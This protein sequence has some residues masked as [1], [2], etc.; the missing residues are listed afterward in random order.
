MI[1]SQKSCNFWAFKYSKYRQPASN[2]NRKLHITPKTPKEIRPPFIQGREDESSMGPT[3]VL[4]QMYLPCMLWR[5]C[6]QPGHSVNQYRINLFD[7]I[8]SGKLHTF[9]VKLPQWR[10]SNTRHGSQ[11][12]RCLAVALGNLQPSLRRYAKP[13][14]PWNVLR[15]NCTKTYKA[16]TRT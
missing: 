15:T 6:T 5:I 11:R 8:P 16:Q 3:S 9:G 10:G 4:Y 13:N 1:K 7:C 2:D 14:S 12:S